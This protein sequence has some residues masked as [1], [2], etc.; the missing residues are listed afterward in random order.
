[1]VQV[2][3]NWCYHILL[4]CSALKSHSFTVNSS[5]N[6]TNSYNKRRMSLTKSFLQ[7]VTA[8]ASPFLTTYGKQTKPWLSCY[9]APPSTQGKLLAGT[10]MAPINHD[11]VVYAWD[12]ARVITPYVL[13]DIDTKPDALA[14]LHDEASWSPMAELGWQVDQRNWACTTTYFQVSARNQS[15][16]D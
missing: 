1:M 2:L 14:M 8:S 16:L 9:L 11:P 7:L 12:R 10:F 4:I 3:N 15:R 6:I 5:M 13:G